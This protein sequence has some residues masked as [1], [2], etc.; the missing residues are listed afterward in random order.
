MKCKDHIPLGIDEIPER[1]VVDFHLD[2][3]RLVGQ[4]ARVGVL[5]EHKLA[6]RCDIEAD[7]AT[8]RRRVARSL[9]FLFTICKLNTLLGQAKVDEIVC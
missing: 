5:G 9:R 7:D 8:H 2:G 3:E 6:G 1:H 4:D